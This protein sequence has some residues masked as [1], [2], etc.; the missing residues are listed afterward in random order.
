M[1]A[2]F[3]PGRRPAHDFSP[4]ERMERLSTSTP[5]RLREALFYLSG[6]APSMLDAILD[7]TE[8]FTLPCACDSDEVDTG[9]EDVDNDPFM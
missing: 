5:E 4:Q 7:A 2:I 1:T 9:D 6:F 3:S 8:P